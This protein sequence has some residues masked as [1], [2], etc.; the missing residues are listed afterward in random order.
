MIRS[1]IQSALHTLTLAAALAFGIGCSP[2]TPESHREKPKPVRTETG[3][4]ILVPAGTFTMGNEA[5]EPDERPAHRVRLDAFLIDAYEVT[6][7][8]FQALRGK[9]TSHFKHPGRP[10]EQVGWAEAALYCNARS[11]AEGLTPCYDEMTGACNFGA[12]GYRLPTEAEWEYACRAGSEAAYPFGSDATALKH[13]AWFREN[14]EEHTHPVGTRAP[15]AWGLHDMCGNVMEWC[16]DVYDA[17]YYAAALEAKPRGPA[18]FPGAKF[19]VRGG[20]WT[21]SATACR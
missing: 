14:A 18:D 6:Q 12:N 7:K 17:G 1:S 9:N 10:V 3:D 2:T 16:N 21:S 19:V 20:A 15:N 11:R 5:G 8:Q 4:M 13:Y